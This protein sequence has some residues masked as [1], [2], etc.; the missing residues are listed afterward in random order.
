MTLHDCE[1]E[2]ADGLDTARFAGMQRPRSI[3]PLEPKRRGAVWGDRGRFAFL[4]AAS[5]SLDHAASCDDRRPNN[6]LYG[7]RVD[8]TNTNT[9]TNR[10]APRLGRHP[11]R[12]RHARPYD[13]FGCFVRTVLLTRAPQDLSSVYPTPSYPTILL[14]IYPS[15]HPSLDITFAN[16]SST[17]DDD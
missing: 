16:R 5:T 7:T 1:A 15:I 13:A 10:A 12:R 14:P 11:R 4:L 3:R 9:N 6:C 2:K 17:E 8:D